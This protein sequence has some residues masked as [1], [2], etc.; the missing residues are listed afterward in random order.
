MITLQQ[1]PAFLGVRAHPSAT[2]FVHT[3]THT[4]THIHGERERQ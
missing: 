3:H 1:M 2:A 4:H